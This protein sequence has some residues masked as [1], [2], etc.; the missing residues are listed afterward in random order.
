MPKIDPYKVLNVP[1]GAG[2][3][4]IE[5]AYRRAVERFG[6]R[7][8]DSP[9]FAA[10]LARA[11]EAY[12]TLMEADQERSRREREELVAGITGIYPREFT[13]HEYL[14]RRKTLVV[15]AV[16]LLAALH[17]M[18][19]APLLPLSF[20]GEIK[21]IV[22]TAGWLC[23]S[24]GLLLLLKFY[25]APFRALKAMQFHEAAELLVAMVMAPLFGFV[26]FPCLFSGELARVTGRQ[27]IVSRYS[28]VPVSNRTLIPYDVAWVFFLVFLVASLSM[29]KGGISGLLARLID[30][31]R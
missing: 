6:P 2:R 16:S 9:L 12:E 24:W 27:W 15:F 3:R 30:R 14:F 4:E 13:L 28:S 20:M 1:R 26:V 8:G 7:A 18:P 29:R 11:A 5:A 22:V 23:L 10:H 19:H 31:R 25:L 21:R 17:F